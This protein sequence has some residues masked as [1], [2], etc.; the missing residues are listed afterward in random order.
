MPRTTL[1]ALLI[2]CSMLLP[3]FA[4]ADTA[5]SRLDELIAEYLDH[6]R[7][8]QPHVASRAGLTEYAGDL[9]D[10]SAE[11]LEA[12]AGRLAAFLERLDAIDPASMGSVDHR[13][14]HDLLGRHARVRLARIRDWPDWRREPGMYMPFS[15]FT[16][17]L[18][19]RKAP[20]AQRA[21]WLLARMEALPGLLAAGRANLQ[22]PPERFTR[23]AI[24]AVDG[25]IAFF[26][27]AVPD[28][29]A[30]V[31]DQRDAL[32]ESAARVRGAL[33]DWRTFLREDLLPRSDGDLAAGSKAYGFYLREIHGL[34]WTPAELVARGQRY[35]DETREL[36]EVQARRID[37]ERTWVEITERIRND[38]PR[39][40][41]LLDAYCREIHRAR[42]HVI[43]ERLATVPDG[44]EVRCISS[45]PSQRA[46]S[47]F[48]VFRTPA[49]YSDRKI[50]YLILHP[51]DD[52]LDEAARERVLR[53]HDHTWIQ[54]IA[55]HEAYPGHHLQ[56]LIAQQHDRP[57]RKVYS[58]PVFTEGW[59]LYT[60]EL[61]HETGFFRPAAETRL[62]Q[63]RLRL[64]RAA[65]VLLDARLHS[66]EITF[67]EARA[68]LA[69]QVRMPESATAGEVNIYAYRP[70]Y[71]IGYVVGYHEMMDL[72]ESRR[73]ALGD[74]FDL[75]AF[76]DRLL[77]VGSIPFDQVRMLMAQ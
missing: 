2:L 44:E 66:G 46:F 62:T 39:A 18:L 34:D 43:D 21:A 28:F 65:R 51:V 75:R 48:G 6:Y 63:L 24:A 56:A 55:G 76:H 73:R 33:E 25:Q 7:Q 10:L 42:D 77:G 15:A 17:L 61:M 72:R 29:A 53:G 5:E 3:A 60:E 30:Q 22:R 59:G 45:D 49:P 57:L 67:D 64:W 32:E 40:D 50:G 74:S 37:P 26:K 54:V 36:L 4:A 16:D 11:A 23:D 68:F 19:D 38:H 14:D 41:E 69:E 35:F 9:P 71:A 8:S 1:P 70:S 13:V 52:S 12:R 58:T 27:D 47:P 20:A 31:P